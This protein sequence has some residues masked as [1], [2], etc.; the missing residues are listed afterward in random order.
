MAP[1]PMAEY[2]APGPAGGPLRVTGGKTRSEYMFSALPQIA[3]IARSE[4]HN[5]VSQ[6]YCRSRGLGI[7]R[8]GDH[9]F[10]GSCVL[11]IM[12]SGPEQ[13]HARLWR[14]NATRLSGIEW[15]WSAKRA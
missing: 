13:F 3:D 2:P 14:N 10:W 5:S 1:F 6:P 12:R 4:F 15:L 9:A 11:G 7:M 8:A